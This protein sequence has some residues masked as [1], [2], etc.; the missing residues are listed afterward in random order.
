ML[1]TGEKKTD[2]RGHVWRMR[3]TLN[4]Q[5]QTHKI[6]VQI[7]TS[8]KKT[9]SSDLAIDQPDVKRRRAGH[10]VTRLRN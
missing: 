6:Y 10:T 1:H 2:S 7:V 5:H 9:I 4:N 8:V 3:K